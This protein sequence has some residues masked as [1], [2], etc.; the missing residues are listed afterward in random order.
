MQLYR[1]LLI[2]AWVGCDDKV[3][4]E[5][6]TLLQWVTVKG[7][8]RLIW[9]RVSNESFRYFGSFVA[10]EGFGK[11]NSP[12]KRQQ[13]VLMHANETTGFS[14]LC[15]SACLSDILEFEQVSILLSQDIT[16]VWPASMINLHRICDY[17]R[18]I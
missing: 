1:T 15:P 12:P 9:S 11:C 2:G 3:M 18:A 10:L 5:I 6:A 4:H 7:H 14:L 17:I 8:L 13:S 16:L